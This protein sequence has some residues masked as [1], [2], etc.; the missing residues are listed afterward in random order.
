MEAI[1]YSNFRQNLRGYMKQINEDSDTFIVT[2]KN[3]EDT[4]VV[5]SKRDYDAM[6]ET[7]RTL[8]NSY[9]MDKIRRGDEQFQVG[10]GTVREL[11]EAEND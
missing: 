4:V 8:S 5:M 1:A 6:Q 10:K 7:L 9:V 2:T 3:V 11:I